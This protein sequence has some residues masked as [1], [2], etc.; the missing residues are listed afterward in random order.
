MGKASSRSHALTD[1]RSLHTPTMAL[2]CSCGAGCG[3]S[4][5]GLIR[6]HELEPGEFPSVP[7]DRER[8]G[9]RGQLASAASNNKGGIRV[10]SELPTSGV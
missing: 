6:M 5:P 10:K 1:N 7:G 2:P 4:G 3:Q 9:S 8:S